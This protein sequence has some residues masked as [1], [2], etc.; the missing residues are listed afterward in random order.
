MI[1]TINTT[2]DQRPKTFNAVGMNFT[3]DI[4]FGMMAD[5]KVFITEPCHMV[6]TREFIGVEDSVSVNLISHEG[7]EGMSFNIWNNLC[8]YLAIPLNCSKNFSLTIRTSATLATPYTAHISLVNFHFA[9]KMLEI[10]IHKS[11][12]LFEHSP[13]CLIGNTRFPLNLLG[14]YTT[15][16]GSHAIYDLKPN[17]Q[18]SRRFAEYS[19]SERMNLMP[20]VVASITLT[21][22]YVMM[23]SYLL[24]FWTIN[25]IRPE[26][27]FYPSQTTNIIREF[28]IKIF[29]SVFIHFTPLTSFDN[30]TIAH[31]LLVVKG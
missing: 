19:V 18:G 15:P 24:T 22:C 16:C 2:L 31:F 7:D 6:I 21:T 1:D 3:P 30:Y 25:T 13:C 5:T 27:V 10:L 14:R 11:A 17:P 8:H 12:N 23:L 4:L 26:V 29:G 20:A 28:I 9:S